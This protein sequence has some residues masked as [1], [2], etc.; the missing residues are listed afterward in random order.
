M[1]L[2][3]QRCYAPVRRVDAAYR[4]YLLSIREVFRLLENTGWRRTYNRNCY[5]RF[6]PRCR[7][8]P[9]PPAPPSDQTGMA[10]TRMSSKPFVF[11]V[12]FRAFARRLSLVTS[13]RQP[14]QVVEAVVVAWNDVVA[15]GADSVA[16][17]RVSLRF[18]SS[19]RASLD[20]GAACRPVVRQSQAPVACVP[21][22]PVA[23]HAARPLSTSPYPQPITCRGETGRSIRAGATSLGLH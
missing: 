1:R 14:L 19:V 10:F 7:R 22:H 4:G 12:P 2:V 9:S 20:G 18:A 8:S 3:S 6:H 21:V 17:F 16:S 5:R 11:A 23:R 15:I 13:I